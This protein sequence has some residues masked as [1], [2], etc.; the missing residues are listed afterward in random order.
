[1]GLQGVPGD[2][3]EM[4][5]SIGGYQH[6]GTGDFGRHSATECIEEH[7]KHSAR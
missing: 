4:V 5:E 1:M 6:L 3:Y 2:L 7:A